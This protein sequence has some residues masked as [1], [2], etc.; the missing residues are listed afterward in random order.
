MKRY[1]GADKD[2]E[3]WVIDPASGACFILMLTIW[4]GVV[5]SEPMYDLKHPLHNLYN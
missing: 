1:G 5:L 2:E 4:L 3:S